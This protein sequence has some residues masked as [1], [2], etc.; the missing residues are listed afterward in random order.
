ML[1][2][3]VLNKNVVRRYLGIGTQR[4][5]SIVANVAN[6]SDGLHFLMG[7]VFM[8]QPTFRTA[9]H[10]PARAAL[11]LFGDLHGLM[12]SINGEFYGRYTACCLQSRTNFWLLLFCGLVANSHTILIQIFFDRFGGIGPMSDCCWLGWAGCFRTDRFDCMRYS[13]SRF[14]WSSFCRT[15]STDSRSGAYDMCKMPP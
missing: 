3:D 8:L 11:N 6:L 1:G 4:E 13:T 9:K 5:R 12:K 15:S 14:R 10:L 7:V 2:K